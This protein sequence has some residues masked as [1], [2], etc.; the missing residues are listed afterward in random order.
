MPH[1][2]YSRWDGTQTGFDVD[3]D[4]LFSEMADDLIYHGDV[5]SALRQM[6]Q[7]GMIDRDGRQMEGIRDMMERLRERRRDILENHDLGGVFDDIANELRELVDD[8]RTSLEEM[9]DQADQSGDARRQELASD[10]SAMKNMELDMLPPDLAGQV[11]GLQNYDFESDE[12]EQRFNELMD[13]LRE[14]IMQQQLDQMAEGINDMAPEEMQR[15]KDMLAELNHMLEQRAAGEEPDFDGFMERFGDFFPEAPQTLDELLEI[16]AQ[17]MAQMQQMMNSM[18]PEQRQQLQELSSQLMEDMDLQFQISQLSDNLR[19]QFPQMG[20]GQSYD[21]EGSDPLDMPQAMDMM[22][23]LGDIDQLDN[24]LR[25]ATNPGALAE[26]D[27][28]RARDLLGEES[29]ES[30]ERMAEIARMLEESGLI[31]NKE[32]RY[33]LTP[34]AIRRI[35]NDAL[36]EI[37]KRMSPDM[38]GKHQLERTGQ[39]HERDFDT[40]AYEYGDRFNLHIEKTLRNAVARTGGGIP[41]QLHAEDFEIERTEQLTRSS[42]VLMLDISMSMAMRD[43]FLPAK[44]VTMALHSLISSQYPRD[45]LGM[46]SFSEVAREFTAATLPELS[47][48]YVYGTNMQHAFQ[49]ARQM[50][51]KQTGTK[52]I[53][54][55]TDG[56]PTAH[57]SKNGQPY[58]NYP[59]SQ[60]TVDLTLT[61]V[62]KATR[63]DIR[64]NT[65]VLDVTHY[66]QNFVE[67]ISRMNGGRAFF[68]TNEELGDYLLMDFVD[69]KRSL[70]RGRR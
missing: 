22:G 12:A 21:F 60:Q 70:L 3:A 65:F 40:K 19:E 64:I 43:N 57:I 39:G 24:L 69:Q 41:V 58:F 36:E 28:D 6:M 2:S 68:T 16:M 44:K 38:L 9:V 27:I 31:E 46:V 7:G 51:S 1:F 13:K 59:P 8:E 54:M 25:G 62:A 20:W 49:I 11:K 23:E 66:L 29:A 50:L 30:L 48:D 15:V 52:Q 61:E 55:I 53:I 42:T 26:V 63:E 33:E 56:E 10:T 4:H 47:W 34:R 32:G 5:N 17:R 37:F 14:Q 45:F 67:Q 35:G 18:S